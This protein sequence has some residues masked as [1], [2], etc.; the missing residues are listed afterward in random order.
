MFSNTMEDQ[1]SNDISEDLRLL[2][3]QRV[4]DLSML[5]GEPMEFINGN[6]ILK[7]MIV[8]GFII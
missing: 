6:I 3:E 5:D 7:L 4:P 8:Y 2:I 1:V